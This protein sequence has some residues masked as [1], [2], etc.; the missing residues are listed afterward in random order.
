M[1]PVTPN[2]SRML[3]APPSPA[4]PSSSALVRANRESSVV[5][6][7]RGRVVHDLVKREPRSPPPSVKSEPIDHATPRTPSKGSM[8]P[9]PTAPS[10]SRKRKAS[11]PFRAR[12]ATPFASP[13]KRQ[14][15]SVTPSP[16][17]R[18]VSTHGPSPTPS[19]RS[20]LDGSD[21][22]ERA[23]SSFEE[24]IEIDSPPSSPTPSQR[25]MTPRF[26]TTSSRSVRGMSEASEASN[27]SFMTA[28]S[29]S[30]DRDVTPWARQ[31]IFDT[32][33]RRAPRRPRVGDG[34]SQRSLT[35]QSA[36][37]VPM[38]A[39]MERA[40]EGV[41]TLIEDWVRD[42]AELDLTEDD[43]PT[44]GDFLKMIWRRVFSTFDTDLVKKVVEDG[45][46][47]GTEF[48]VHDV[49]S[50]IGSASGQVRLHLASALVDYSS[51][52]KAKNTV[53]RKAEFYASF[54]ISAAQ[55]AQIN[56]GVDRKTA[57]GMISSWAAVVTA[58]VGVL[59]EDVRSTSPGADLGQVRDL[60]RRLQAMMEGVVEE[61]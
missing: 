15:K 50:F 30:L 46:I 13:V 4:T 55:L 36:Q 47:C 22:L 44:G 51:A 54:K 1:L 59:L 45:R 32:A 48:E 26:P 3:I 28:T 24:A 19:L 61:A 52:S 2:H 37:I 17:R 14:T 38:P 49:A 6:L 56:A 18:R 9:P 43:A 11:T 35:P 60:V 5:P 39:E 27:R 58:N 20:V 8:G 40:A 10:S 12:S 41:K 57:L 23:G 33:D 53:Q 7:S 34:G 29:A 25:S 16:R 42:A 31:T 21:G